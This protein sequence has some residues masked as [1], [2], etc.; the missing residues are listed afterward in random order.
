MNCRLFVR[1]PR[2]ISLTEEGE[3]L[4]SHVEIA[5]R[6]LINAQEEIYRQ[7]SGRC[8]TVE[9]GVTETALHLFLLNALRGFKLEYPAIR[10]KIHNHTTPET[11]GH[12]ISGKLDFA[13][14][15][16]P[17]EVPK[18]VSCVKVLDFEEILVGGMQYENLRKGAL[19]LE[20][21]KNYPWVGLG[22]ESAAYRWYKDFFIS[23]KID[24]EPDMEVATFDLILPL[25][26]NNFGIG[27]VPGKLAQPLLEEG[28]IV[29]IPV[30]CHIPE[31]SIQML[32]DKGRGKG[33]A[34][35]T[36]YRYLIR[37]SALGC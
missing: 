20:E 35:D 14:V 26:E 9:I 6:H 10:I 8:G 16:T 28:R 24:I 36:L 25:I 7:D 11:V 32:A 12:L 1:E 2:G 19:E 37:N 31:R 17:F 18:N 33:M 29:Q 15:T 5:Y 22:K 23:H 13:V 4:Y 21:I 34:A 27:F 30:K 3:L